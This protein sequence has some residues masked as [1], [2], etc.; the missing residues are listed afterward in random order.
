MTKFKHENAVRMYDTDAAGILYFA[1]QFRFVHD[2]F[3]ALMEHEGVSI[4]D[5]FKKS[6]VIFV[7]VNANSDY[8][9]PLTLGDKLTIYC[10]V[11]RI[12]ATSVTFFY[13]L[14]KDEEL[15]GKAET[16]HV[17]L[18]KISRT[19]QVIPDSFRDKLEK[20]HLKS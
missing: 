10:H 4:Q 13:E 19:K 15:V 2:S 3:E 9:Q 18:N 11:K 1:S 12:G 14:F 20:Y 16:T 6:D 17:C 7:I 5:M 8:I